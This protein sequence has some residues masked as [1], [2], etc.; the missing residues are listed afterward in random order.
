MNTNKDNDD[1]IFLTN[2]TE[3]IMHPFYNKQIVFTGALSTMTRAEAAKKAR[4]CGGLMQ[5]A[6]TKDTAF[7]ILGHNR[8]GKSTKHL[9]AEQLIQLGYDIQII[10]EEDFIWLISMQKE[11]IPSSLQ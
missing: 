11:Y 5:G 6:V 8:R 9:K 3:R 4:A 10:A 2:L 7:V 1:I